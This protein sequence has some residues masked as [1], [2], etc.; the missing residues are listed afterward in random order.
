MRR[1]RCQAACAKHPQD[2]VSQTTTEYLRA[3]SQPAGL[4]SSG[5]ERPFH[6][7]RLRSSENTFPL[8]L[9][10]TTPLSSPSPGGSAHVQVPP[11]TVTRQS[12]PNKAG[13]KK[14][15]ASYCL[16]FRLFVL[17]SPGTLRQFTAIFNNGNTDRISL[18]EL[19][20]LMIIKK[21]YVY[22]H[23][24]EWRLVN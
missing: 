19:A 15:L 5:V 18:N 24:L 9:G 17:I 22:S 21:H 3:G 12:Y 7:D 2:S 6:R 4:A 14:S 16:T 13:G 23:D 8:G 11:R 1:Q 20:F 10:T